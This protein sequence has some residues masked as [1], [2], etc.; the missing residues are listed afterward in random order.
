MRILLAEA[1]PNQREALRRVLEAEQHDVE[2]VADAPAAQKR[3]ESQ[4]YDLVIVDWTLPDAQGGCLCHCYHRHPNAGWVLT[5]ANTCHEGVA[6]LDAGADD[7]VT[8]PVLPQELQARIRAQLRR[9][10]QH[11]SYADLVL[12][13]DQ[14]TLERGERR[15]SLTKREWQLLEYIVRR[16]ERVISHQ[17]LTQALWPAPPASNALAKLVRRVRQRLASIGSEDWL[18]S[19]YGVGYRLSQPDSFRTN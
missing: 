2:C 11:L 6:S 14:I 8:K 16:P 19:I 9:R 15:T 1:D 17:E 3:L 10:P 18:E 13:F 7:F 12:N 5:I 4:G